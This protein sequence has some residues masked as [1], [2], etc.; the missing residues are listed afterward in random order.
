MWS[1]DD[2]DMSSISAECFC[3]ET[4]LAAV[5]L[6]LIGQWLIILLL[7]L[8]M[9]SLACLEGSEFKL[10]IHWNAFFLSYADHWKAAEQL[11]FLTTENFEQ[12]LKEVSPAENFEFD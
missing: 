9:T 5:S 12:E 11:R 4:W 6:K 10:I 7:Q 2:S 8:N 1:S 3:W